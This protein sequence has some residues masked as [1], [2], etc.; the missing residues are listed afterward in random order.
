MN[1][2]ELLEQTAREFQSIACLGMDPV[3]ERIPLEWEGVEGRL[4]GFY[5]GILEACASSSVM[6]GAVKPNY[7]FFAQYGFDGLKALKKVIGVAKKEGLP[8]ILDAKRGDIGATAK[9]Y[10]KEVFEFWEADCVTISPYMGGDSVRPFIE[11]C[12]GKGK[13]VYILTRT[14]NPGAAD[15]QNL[16][17]AQGQVFEVVSEKVLGW[18]KNAKGSV[19]VVVGATSLE[20]FEKIHSFF[21]GKKVPFL[22]PGVGAQGGSASEVAGVLRKD[23]EAMPLHRINSS[24]GI[25][26]AWEREKTKDFAG[27]AVRELDRLNKEIAFKA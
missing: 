3:L 20:E 14:S 26:Y 17:T 21:R 11:W 8:V 7:A 10:S 5:A 16:S 4:T 1:Y 25:N 2:S 15:F 27:A 23:L 9:A 18:G 6:P 13:G 24:S 19:G 12:E 22:I